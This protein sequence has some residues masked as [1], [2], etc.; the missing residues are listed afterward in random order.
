MA[1]QI[2]LINSLVFT[3]RAQK[4][5]FILFVFQF[6]IEAQFPCCT[7]LKC[8]SASTSASILWVLGFQCL[9][10]MNKANKN[11]CVQV[12]ACTYIFITPCKYL[13]SELLYYMVN[14][15][16]LLHKIVKLF[17][18]VVQ[19]QALNTYHHLMFQYFRFQ[20]FQCVCVVITLCHSNCMSSMINLLSTFPHT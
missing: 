15:Y 7:D 8:S 2:T 9:A 6:L 4:I 3:I 5:L 20:N 12:S 16:I 17:Y 14:V 18:K 19:S 10:I 1:I 13:R 11:I